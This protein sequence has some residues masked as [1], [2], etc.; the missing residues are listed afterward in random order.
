MTT[1]HT[2]DSTGEAYDATQ[3]DE[4]VI[5]GHTLLVPR[6]GVVGLS[7]TWPVAVTEHPGELHAMGDARAEIA[8]DA[9]W[10]TALIQ[11]A[12]AVAIEHNLPVAA[13][14][15]AAAGDTTLPS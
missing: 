7:W 14:A 2:Y 8:A 6:E 3:C 5:A 13:W 11:H 4:H 10:T 9:G 12:V 1:T 15:C